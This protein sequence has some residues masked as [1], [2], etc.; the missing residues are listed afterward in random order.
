MMGHREPLKGG[1]E[2]DVFTGWRKVLKYTARAGVC[3]A[4]KTKF[5]R[6]QRRESKEEIRKTLD[7]S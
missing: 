4:I 3:R 5:N 2:W 1:D 6:R 7:N